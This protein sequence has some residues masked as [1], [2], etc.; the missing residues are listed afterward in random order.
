MVFKKYIVFSKYVI[1]NDPKALSPPDNNGVMA[2][3]S[4]L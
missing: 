3:D 4:G 2:P 1:R